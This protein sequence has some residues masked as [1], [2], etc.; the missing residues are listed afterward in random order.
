[1]RGTNISF[2]RASGRSSTLVETT[3]REGGGMQKV[4]HSS[5]VEVN[6][7][8]CKG[9]IGRRFCRESMLSKRYKYPRRLHQG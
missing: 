1:M 9:E 6:A 7:V 5:S 4:M 2:R 3:A 8:C